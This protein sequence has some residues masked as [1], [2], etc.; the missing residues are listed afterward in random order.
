MQAV[1]S[2]RESFGSKWNQK[3]IENTLENSLFQQNNVGLSNL[4]APFNYTKQVEV[5]SIIK[6]EKNMID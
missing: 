2:Y 5:K 6:R 1:R 4:T 3:L